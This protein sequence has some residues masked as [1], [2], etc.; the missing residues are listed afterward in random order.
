[1]MESSAF[2]AISLA[3]TLVFGE[4][5]AYVTKS[6][7]TCSHI[8]PSWMAVHAG[9][10]FFFFFFFFCHHLPFMDITSG[11]FES[12]Q[13]NACVHR[14]D[15]GFH[16]HPKEFLVLG[17]GVKTQVNSKKKKPLC[18]RLK[19]L[20]PWPCIMQDNKPNTLPTE[21][22]QPLMMESSCSDWFASTSD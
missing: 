5:F 4:I 8:L 15:L 16:S 1:M 9:R 13:W 17:N 18:Q 19:W 11:S 7:C 12:M 3:F 2:P 22:H 20:N 14:L 10:G 21:L 6:N